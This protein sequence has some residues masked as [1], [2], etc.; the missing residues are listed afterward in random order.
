MWTARKSSHSP[1]TFMGAGLRV[2]SREGLRG[3]REPGAGK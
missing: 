1:G 3:A 2:I